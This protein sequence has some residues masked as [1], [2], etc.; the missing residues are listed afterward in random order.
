MSAQEVL[1]FLDDLFEK[2]RN[3]HAPIPGISGKLVVFST[4]GP[5]DDNSNYK[6]LWAEGK[7]YKE[8]V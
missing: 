3:R 2:T 7:L 6:R 4:S 1:A 5:I 8:W